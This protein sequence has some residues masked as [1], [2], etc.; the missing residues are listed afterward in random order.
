MIESARERIEEALEPG[1]RNR[2]ETILSILRVVRAEHGLGA[3]Q[4]LIREYRL[5]M[6]FPFSQKLVRIGEPR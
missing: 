6:G 4:D 2:N 1:R 5:D 3:A